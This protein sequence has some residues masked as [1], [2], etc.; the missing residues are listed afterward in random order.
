MSKYKLYILFALII[1]GWPAKGLGQTEIKAQRSSL[2]GLQGVGFTVNIEQN[3][4]LTDTQ[5]VKISTI[6]K[7][8]TQV[9]KNGNVHVYSDQQVRSSTRIPV[10][11]LHI[12]SHSTRNGIIAFAIN[13]SLYQPVKLELSHD[14]RMTAATWEDGEV[15]LASY[16]KIGVITQ[17]AMGLIKSFIHAY[18]QA[19]PK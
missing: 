18:K 4:A 12:N 11:F 5:L 3:T 17:A 6:K 14:K 9:L 8:G 19:N 16:D 13:I 7:Q 2:Q 15:G 1:F 10:L